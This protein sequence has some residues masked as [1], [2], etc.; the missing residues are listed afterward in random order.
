MKA[1]IMAGGS[2]S[3]LR[4]LTCGRPKPMT[5]LV[6]KPVMEYA[7]ELLRSHGITDIAVTLQYLPESIKDYFGNGS[8]W[9]VNLEYFVEE[10]PLG[11]AGSVKNAQDF[12]DDT[13]IV[14]SGDA[15]TDFNLSAAVDFHFASKALATLVLTP[16]DAPLEY[17]VVVTRSDGRI[18]RFLEKP[19]WG[20]VFS[21]QVNTGIYVLQPE[22]L[23]EIPS[24]G[25]YDFSKDLFPKLYD[26]QAPMYGYLAQGYWCDIGNIEQYRRA[27]MDLLSG[28]VKVPIA[29]NEIAPGIFAGLEVKIDA[30]AQIKGPVVLG[31]CCRIGPNVSIEPY[32]VIGSNVIVE[33][34][35]S[36]KRSILWSGSHIGKQSS[37]RGTILCN[38]VQTGNN[39]SLFEGSVIGDDSELEDHSVVKPEVKLWPHKVV[40]RG[41]TVNASM[42]WGSKS[43]KTLF[44]KDGVPG[45]INVD[46]T[47]EFAARLGG[48]YGGTLQQGQRVLVSSDGQPGAEMIKDAFISGLLSTGV[49]VYEAGPLTPALQRFGVGFLGADGGAYFKTWP[50]DHQRIRIQFFDSRGINISRDSERKIENFFHREDFRRAQ[51][52]E[53]NYVLSAPDFVSAY[54]DF[55]SREVNQ[56][57][58][59]Y[60]PSIVLSTMGNPADAALKLLLEALGIAVHIV[61]A[62]GYSDSK[63]NLQA[64]YSAVADTVTRTGAL[65]GA[66]VDSHGE[67]LTVVDVG[68][69]IIKGEALTALQALVYFIS[70]R[71]GS[72]V[73]PVTASRVVEDLARDFGGQVVRTKTGTRFILEAKVAEDNRL[74]NPPVMQFFMEFD[75]VY[76]LVKLIDCLLMQSMTLTQL[77]ERIP[78]FFLSVKTTQ[79]PWTAKGTVMRTLINEGGEENVELLDG[80][81]VYHDQ[82]SALVLPDAEDPVYNVYGEGF[83]QEI[84]DSLT[85]MYVKKIDSIIREKDQENKSQ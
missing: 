41:T 62:K 42:V 18:R 59:S 31:S 12:L 14:I 6:N 40:E 58:W 69:T 56:D 24:Q 52:S 5:P 11:T 66:V 63:E 54:L 36:I 74:S 15:I 84:A 70:N 3:R 83:S 32:T 50:Q 2:G 77:T 21:D 20:E 1:V 37:L 26:A 51:A 4:P 81:K 17:G 25:M 72:F 38:R 55:M 73:V 80:I 23:Q 13:F 79:C 61:E 27:H 16:V 68:G 64:V 10:V 65:F 47:P 46:L 71:G 39:V 82:G 22:V 44:G 33:E 60:N 85:D 76:T 30:S 53:V 29:G 34:G 67:N 48:A 19:G 9:G 57:F 43:G 35:A 28:K 45:K 49:H 7:I 78:E 8:Q 75:Q